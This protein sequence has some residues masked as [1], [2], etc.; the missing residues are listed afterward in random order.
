[1]LLKEGEKMPNIDENI[2]VVKL[3]KQ[4]VTLLKHNMLKGFENTG[5]TAPQGMV[6]GCLCKI[7]KLKVSDLSEKLGL[8]SS[9]VSGIIDR[10][11]KQEMV[12]RTRS[13]EDKR[14]VYVSL[15]H[16]FGEMHH[17]FNSIAEKNVQAIMDRGAQGD[18]DKIIDALNILKKLLSDDIKKDEI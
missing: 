6:I 4:V 3:F 9:T 13:L 14:V 16:R 1:M 15:T 17:N 8:S 12:I 10:L 11:E 18:I 7:D 5:I 2:E